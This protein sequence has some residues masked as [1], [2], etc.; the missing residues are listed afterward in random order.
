[1]GFRLYKSVSLGRGIRLNL[2]KTGV[3]ISAG[4]PGLRYSVHSSGRTVR[5][6]GLPGTGIYYRKD[7]YVRTSPRTTRSQGRPTPAPAVQMYPRAGLFAPREEKLFVKGVTAYM[8]GKHEEALQHFCDVMARDAAQAH[9]SE[10]YFA[11]MAL[12]AL[13]R[14]EEAI[15]PLEQVVSSSEELPDQLM[16]KYGVAGEMLI[17]ITPNVTGQLPVSHLGAA[18]LLAELYQ[19]TGKR[20]KAIELLE[21][22]GSLAPDPIFALSLADLY[23]EE[24]NWNE[25]VRVTEGFENRDDATCELVVL[26]ARALYE[27]GLVEGCIAAAREALR[28]RRRSPELLRLA[29]YLRALAYEASGKKALARRDFERILAEDATFADVAERLGLGSAGSQASGQGA[30]SGA[31]A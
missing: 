20:R 21:S 28:S 24:S 26:R 15:E 18:L 27:L 13:G 1:M 9:V 5:T 23:A 4:I 3:G 14:E 6:A 22:L 16:Q 17:Q 2:S 19:S 25:V 29:R 7:S 10:E 31:D 12:V 30:P 8:Q 11:A